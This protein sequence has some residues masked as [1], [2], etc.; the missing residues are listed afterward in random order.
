MDPK[1]LNKI[2]A[3]LM[4]NSAISKFVSGA[5][6]SEDGKLQLVLTG[7]ADK[8]DIDQLR[9]LLK[10]LSENIAES[11]DVEDLFDVTASGP[12]VITVILNA[13]D[14]GL[15]E[16]STKHRCRTLRDAINAEW[17]W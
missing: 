12:N 14:E 6:S 8:L 15:H 7:N 13:D 10:K 16:R 17:P 11:G 9:T 1:I 4:A 5:V 3:Q 2:L